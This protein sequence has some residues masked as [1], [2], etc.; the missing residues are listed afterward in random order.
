MALYGK[1]KIVGRD[2]P[3]P[4]PPVMK[5]KTVKHTYPRDSAPK[6]S[7]PPPR[8]ADAPPPPPPPPPPQGDGAASGAGADGGTLGVDLEEYRRLNAESL[9]AALAAIESEFGLTREQL[10]LSRDAI[11]DEYRYLNLQAERAREISAEQAVQGAQ[12]RGIFRSGITAEA[13][14]D[15]EQAFADQLAQ[16]ESNRTS[17]EEQIDAQLAALEQQEEL[18]RLEAERAAEQALLDLEVMQALADAGI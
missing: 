10:M 17:Q 1:P 5:K 7:P 14:S 11:G 6:S 12:E 15:V 13:V 18:R 16:L 9:E 3:D 8:P 4:N 2:V